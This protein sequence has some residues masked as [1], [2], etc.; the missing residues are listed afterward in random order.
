MTERRAM[1]SECR[2]KADKICDL[3]FVL[4]SAFTIVH[5]EIPRFLA[6]FL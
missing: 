2:T 6:A 5:F 1:N 4:H 3:F